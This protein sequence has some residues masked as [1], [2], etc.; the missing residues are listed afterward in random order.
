MSRTLILSLLLLCASVLRAERTA[1]VF[2]QTMPPR[3]GLWLDSRHMAALADGVEVMDAAGR[4]VVCVS[5]SPLLLQTKLGDDTAFDLGVVA[6]RR[7]TVLV[8]VE[9]LDRPQPDSRVCLYTTDWQTY[10]PQGVLQPALEDWLT[11]DGR[12]NI[13]DVRRA[14]PFM[15]ATAVYNPADRTVTFRHGAQRYL[16]PETDETRRIVSYLKPEITYRFKGGR[17]VLK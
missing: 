17:F 16:G 2:L 15:F 11:K 13:D 6:S 14:L 8:T 12:R 1:A 3:A 9:T 4:N 7:D 10:G 5:D